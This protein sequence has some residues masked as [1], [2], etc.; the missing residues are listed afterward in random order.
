[1]TYGLFKLF[2]SGAITLEINHIAVV[3]EP[4]ARV[5]GCCMRKLTHTYHLFKLCGPES[6]CGCGCDASSSSRGN[7]H[8]HKLR[9]ANERQQRLIRITNRHAARKR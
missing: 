5:S 1:M 7:K 3:I 2:S 6:L 4:S 8:S 9:E